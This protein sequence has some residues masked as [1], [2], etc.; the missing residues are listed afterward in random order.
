MRS[1]GGD[2]CECAERGDAVAEEGPD[3]VALSA[4]VGAGGTS[5]FIVNWR[6]SVV[7]GGEGGLRADSSSELVE[8]MDEATDARRNELS[9][10][11]PLRLTLLGPRIFRS[12]AYSHWRPRVRH[13][14]QGRSPLHYRPFG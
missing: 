7:N 4:A 12:G 1:R 5:S 11:A 14:W 2:D 3:A 13:L 9:L 8:V 6:G 10:I